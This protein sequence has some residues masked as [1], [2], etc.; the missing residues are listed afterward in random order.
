MRETVV[1]SMAAG[2]LSCANTVRRSNAPAAVRLTA[3]FTTSRRL[4]RWIMLAFPDHLD[5]IRFEGWSQYQGKCGAH[6]ATRAGCP[7]NLHGRRM[8]AKG[9]RE[10]PRAFAKFRIGG[11][12]RTD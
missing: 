11:F 4:G 12:V 6:I 7:G 5:A 1:R 9:T 2:T 10:A 8:L 3:V